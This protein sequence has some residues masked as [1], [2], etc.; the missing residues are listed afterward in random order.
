MKKEAFFYILEESNEFNKTV[1]Q[2]IKN[3]YKIK[4]RIILTSQDNQLIQDLNDLLWTFEQI[5]FIPHSTYENFNELTPVFL[6]NKDSLPST[7]NLSF[8]DTLF[9]LGQEIPSD[10]Q[11]YE[12]IVEFV[13]PKEDSKIKSREHYLFY[14]KNNFSINHE[15]ILSNG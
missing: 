13:L 2:I 5:S 7:F 1:C 3:F 11:N 4:S 15:T 6:C 12:K 8:F 10:Y 14:K 9:N